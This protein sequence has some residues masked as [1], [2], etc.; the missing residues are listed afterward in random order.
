MATALRHYAAW[1]LIAALAAHSHGQSSASV[2]TDEGSSIERLKAMLERNHYPLSNV[3]ILL[4]NIGKDSIVAALNADEPLNPASVSK[5]ATAAMAFDK[6][7]TGFTFKTRFYTDGPYNQDSGVCNGNLYVKGGGDPLLVIERMWIIVQYLH[8]FYGLKAINGDI[9]LDDSFFDTAS[10]GPCFIEDSLASN[11]YAAPVGALCANFN[12]VEVCVRPGETIEAPVKAE[13]F[14]RLPGVDVVVR[15]KTVERRKGSGIVVE[16]EQENKQT[17]M[18]VG[19]A[20]AKDAQPHFVLR[21]VRQT[22]RYFG[23]V[24]KMFFDENN[25]TVR[26]KIRRGA[27]PDSIKARA[28]LYTWESPPLREIV[29]DMMK[30]STNLSAEMLFKTFSALRDSGGGSWEKSS[31]SPI[32][33]NGSGMGDCNRFSASQ[34]GALLTF[35]WGQKAYLPEYL[36]AFP[37]AGNDGTLR[38]RFKDSRLKMYV[39][40]KT[41]TL[42]DQGVYTMAGYVLLPKAEYVFVIIFNH[43][44]SKY[45]YQH[46]EMQQKIL[47]MLTP[48]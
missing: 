42:N 25:I 33:K 7:G 2:S 13:V 44:G 22:W 35:V 28:P 47:E 37:V 20:M 6:L 11:P 43:M 21:K 48:Q 26:G 17:R 3:G 1:I 38:S 40:G 9:V 31:E 46:W 27:T 29:A 18:I 8:R 23:S 24:L 39:R 10:I 45:P 15:A 30:F 19:G 4:K 36:N 14:P 5:C 16:S 32:I 34:L 41:G 12:T